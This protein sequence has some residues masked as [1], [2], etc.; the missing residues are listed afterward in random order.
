MQKDP[1]DSELR[2]ESRV[3]SQLSRVMISGERAVFAVVGVL[4]FCAAL[5]LAWRSVTSIG[6]LFT[7]A[8]PT[9]IPTV[10]H[11]LDLILLL[12]MIAEIAYT[13]TKS[14]CGE[15]LSPR[16]FL[17]VGLIAVIRRILVS[18]VQE[19]GPG[20]GGVLHAATIDLAIL[21]LVVL[22]F[23]FSIYLLSRRTTPHQ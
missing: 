16:P 23:V 6:L 18:T 20:R 14:V 13:V 1:P 4:L 3:F 7:G 8:E 2:A 15:V 11:F 22:V 12:L 17:I 21:T 10:S 5:A 19:V 9:V